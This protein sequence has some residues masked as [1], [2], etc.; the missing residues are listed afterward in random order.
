MGNIS[1]LQQRNINTIEN[2][3][4]DCFTIKVTYTNEVGWRRKIEPATRLKYRN[5]LYISSL[6]LTGSRERV[7]VVASKT[8]LP[9]FVTVIL[10]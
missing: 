1:L 8:Q 9:Y 6:K 7:T 10:V 5:T 4:G 3:W 2:Q